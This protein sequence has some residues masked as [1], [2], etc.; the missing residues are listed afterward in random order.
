[1]QVIKGDEVH[2][3]EIKSTFSVS[4]FI[5]HFPMSREELDKSPLN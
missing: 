4:E 1:M 2:A 3:S 5:E